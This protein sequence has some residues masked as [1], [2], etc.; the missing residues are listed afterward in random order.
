MKIFIV[1]I[2]PEMFNGP[3]TASIVQRPGKKVW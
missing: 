3:L 2:F 1:T